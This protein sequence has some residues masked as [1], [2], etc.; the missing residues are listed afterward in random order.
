MAHSAS[1]YSA[2]TFILATGNRGKLAEFQLFF[3]PL[4][5]QIAA[6][7]D[8]QVPEV[9]ETGLGFVENAL[10]KARHASR[11]TGLP[12]LAD[13]S[14]IAVDYLQG[15][16]GI[17]SARFAERQHERQNERQNKHQDGP[18][19]DPNISRDQANNATLLHALAGVPEAQRQ[20]AFYC[21]LAFV[22]HADDPVPVIAQGR[23]QGMVTTEPQG[24]QGFGYD[25]LFYV[26][27]LGKSA[28]ELTPEEKLHHSH[29]GL[30]IRDLLVQLQAL[31]LAPA[32]TTAREPV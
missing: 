16:P 5:I 22:R 29:R 32:L 24:E 7:S 8:F 28:A 17:Y 30:A 6:Q 19:H 25:P 27:A 2:S 26:P 9:E 3:K 21:V 23:W 13:D 1:R 20:A 14:G 4:S 10:I 11:V 15:A 18:I 12:A 31:G